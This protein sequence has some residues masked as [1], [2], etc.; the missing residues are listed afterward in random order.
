MN[1]KSPQQFYREGWS[2]CQGWREAVRA[3]AATGYYKDFRLTKAFAQ[4]AL[5]EFQIS[6]GDEVDSEDKAQAMEILAKTL[7]KLYDRHTRF[8]GEDLGAKVSSLA[9]SGYFN[10][11]DID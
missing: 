11:K 4:V 6:T 8:T 5:T 7:A 2:V 10:Q 3:L 1:K 9:E